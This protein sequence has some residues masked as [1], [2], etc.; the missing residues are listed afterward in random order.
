MPVDFREIAKELLDNYRQSILS[1]GDKLNLEEEIATSLQRAYFDGQ[2]A[3][4]RVVATHKCTDH[5]HYKGK[6]K[7]RVNC[8][9]CNFIYRMNHENT[10]N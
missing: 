7:P 9:Q 6:R 8:L 5:P 2:C 1:S 3:G 4:M 10:R